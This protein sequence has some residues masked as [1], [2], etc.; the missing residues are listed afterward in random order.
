MALRLRD[1]ANRLVITI[2]TKKGRHSSPA[3]VMRM[4]RGHDEHTT[5]METAG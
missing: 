5:A 2:G 4:L 3:T 1:V